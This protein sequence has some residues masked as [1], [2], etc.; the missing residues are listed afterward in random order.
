[1]ISIFS[2]Y[3]IVLF[4][5]DLHRIFHIDGGKSFESIYHN[6]FALIL[7]SFSFLQA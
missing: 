3:R 4:S 6:L 1:M 5:V 7:E 2:S